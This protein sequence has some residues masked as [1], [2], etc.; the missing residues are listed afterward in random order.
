MTYRLALL[1]GHGVKPV[2]ANTRNRCKT[3]EAGSC[4]AVPKEVLTQLIE[5]N[6]FIYFCLDGGSLFFADQQTLYRP[7]APQS[8]ASKPAWSSF[9]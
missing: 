5:G 6:D 3:S 1:A 9:C 8:P 7:E 4:G 2:H